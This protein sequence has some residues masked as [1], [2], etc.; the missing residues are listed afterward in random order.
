MRTITY[1]ETHCADCE[2]HK[3]QMVRSGRHPQYLHYCQHPK[4]ENLRG[5]AGII[6]AGE[7]IGGRDIVP[8]WCPLT[9]ADK[10]ESRT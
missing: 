4:F 9:Q 8:Q 10:E 1:T 3:S 6:P 5:F 7:L 2:F